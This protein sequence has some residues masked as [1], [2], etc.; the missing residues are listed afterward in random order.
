MLFTLGI[1]FGIFL[2]IVVIKYPEF[3]KKNFIILDKVEGDNTTIYLSEVNWKTELIV[4][5]TYEKEKAKLFNYAEALEIV[6]NADKFY[7]G[8][9]HKIEEQL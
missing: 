4:N 6:P 3:K 2:T 8:C 9:N 1:V 7:P 5:R